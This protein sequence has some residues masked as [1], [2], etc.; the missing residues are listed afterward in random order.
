MTIRV[1]VL[2]SVAPEALA[3]LAALPG[4]AELLVPTEAHALLSRIA[5]DQ[6]QLVVAGSGSFDWAGSE[7]QLHRI[8]DGEFMRAMRYRHPL[9]L[10]IIGID[11]VADLAA[12]HGEAGVEIYRA[13]IADALRRSLRRIDIVA[14]TGANEIAVLLPETTANGARVV[15]DRARVLAS[16]LI[17]K[18]AAGEDRRALPIKASVSVGVCDAPR[19]GVSS[20]AAFLDAARAALRDA[21][22]SGGD[23]VAI[24]GS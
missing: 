1:L 10:L 19:D 8:L 6:P 12:T 3:A 4:G 9:S 20:D 22:A 24:V 11:H 15:A 14:R 13:A 21:H 5:A 23:R 2:G 17:V 16:H 18:S 7:S